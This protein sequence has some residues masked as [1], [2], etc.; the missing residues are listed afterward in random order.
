MNAKTTMSSMQI[1]MKGGDDE[2]VIYSI[3]NLF[4]L[5]M[6]VHLPA[7]IPC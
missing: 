2:Q 1:A 6:A 5:H 7:Y 4:A 3:H